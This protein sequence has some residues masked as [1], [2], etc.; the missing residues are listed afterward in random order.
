VIRVETK[1]QRIIVALIVTVVLGLAYVSGAL[2]ADMTI[3]PPDFSQMGKAPPDFSEMG[4]APPGFLEMGKGKAPPPII[5][6]GPMVT[7]GPLLTKAPPLAPA[8]SWTGLYVGGDAGAAWVKTPATW[9]PSFAAF[10]IS[11]TDRGTG[12]IGGAHVG[13]NYEFMPDYIAGVE[14]DWSS[15]K[16]GGSFTQPWIA[17][18]GF[19]FPPGS[20]T[21]MSA[22]VDWLASARGRVGYVV[23]PDV[24][25]YATGGAAWARIAYS[26]SENT[27]G[28]A[29]SASGAKDVSGYVVGGGVEWAATNNWLVRAEYLYY[30][31][32]S[33]PSLMSSPGALSTYAWGK[34]TVSVARGGISYKF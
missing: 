16:A 5:G 31:F 2:A 12:F 8:S 17:P 14:G 10:P 20:Q 30:G 19:A 9:D 23:S 26:G 25:A 6:K 1:V 11:G 28:Y 22:D 27:V 29:A 21:T 32:D 24:M 3:P 34:T 7:K 18:P 4:K 13:Y 15:T 33:G